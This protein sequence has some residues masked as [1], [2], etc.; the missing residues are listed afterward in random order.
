MNKKGEK[1]Q[2]NNP[3]LLSNKNPDLNSQKLNY[4]VDP[5]F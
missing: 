5:L 2:R 3:K 1:E 4:Q